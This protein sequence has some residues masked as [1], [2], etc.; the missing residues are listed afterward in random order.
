MEDAPL[1][2]SSDPDQQK[3]ESVYS[4]MTDWN[5]EEVS[6]PPPEFIERDQTENYVTPASSGRDQ[7]LYVPKHSGWVA[8]IKQSWEQEHC[9][10]KNPG[11][12]W[13][14]LLANGEI[15]IQRGAEKYCLT[16]ALR[17]KVLTRNR[18]FWQ[19]GTKEPEDD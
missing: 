1:A 14:H 19:K 3:S 17:N 13:F 6:N 5:P 8:V 4:E 11:E 2:E 10:A 9:Y 7:R 15:Y 12:D 18:L 16:C